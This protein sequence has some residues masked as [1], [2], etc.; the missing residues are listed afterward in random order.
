MSEGNAVIGRIAGVDYGTRRIGIA[1]SDVEQRIAVPATTL[2][3]AGNLKRDAKSVA[4]W[5]IANEARG[6]VVGLPLNMDGTM[7]PQA[8][9]TKRFTVELAA[10]LPG[11]IV[12]TWDERLSSF[13]ADEWLETA[14]QPRMRGKRNPLRDALAATAILRSYLANQNE[15]QDGK[16]SPEK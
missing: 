13:Q 16:V 5:I 3:G 2:P 12:T 15:G 14:G 4:Q 8:E 6:V 9:L 1:I 7:G 11:L 10:E